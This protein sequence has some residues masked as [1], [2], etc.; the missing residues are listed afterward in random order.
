M[1]VCTFIAS[2]CPLKEVVP[3]KEYSIAINLDNGMID[4]GGADDNYFLLPFRDVSDY[5]DMKYG[6]YIEWNYTDG[7]AKQVLKYM[8]A[9]LEETEQLE[10]W[11]VWL[12]DYYEY[13]DSPVIHKQTISVKELTIKDV[14]EINHADIWNNSDRQLPS[15]PSFYRL[16]ITR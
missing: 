11:H 2:N 14:K 4:D 13:E 8:K 3:E 9:A 12:R 15:R 16:I 1:S 6:V 10:L 7:R 5:T